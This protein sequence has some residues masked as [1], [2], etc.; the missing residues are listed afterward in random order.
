MSNLTQ[1]EA[2][3]TW[4][5]AAEYANQNLGAAGFYKKL[6]PYEKNQIDEMIAD[7]SKR[8]PAPTVDWRKVSKQ[9]YRAIM[10]LGNEERRE[11]CDAYHRALRAENPALAAEAGT[12]KEQTT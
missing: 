10:F 8:A 9:L 11:A 6:G 1:Q 3:A 7:I 2:A 5:Y 4:L 12:G